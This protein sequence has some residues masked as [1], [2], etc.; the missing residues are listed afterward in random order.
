[1]VGHKALWIHIRVQL[2]CYEHPGLH[3][4]LIIWNRTHTN[5]SRLVVTGTEPYLFMS[6]NIWDTLEV[7]MCVFY[8][9][10][11][12]ANQYKLYRE[13]SKNQN[14]L[15]ESLR[16]HAGHLTWSPLRWPGTPPER[17]G[18]R[19]APGG[20]CHGRCSPSPPPK[21][22]GHCVTSFREQL[23]LIRSKHGRSSYLRIWAEG[24]F[25][26]ST[27]FGQVDEQEEEWKGFTAG[28]DGWYHVHI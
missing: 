4:T 9:Y 5:T 17:P 27:S 10:L 18:W 11:H 7:R 21:G 12:Y 20:T 14:I 3:P 13:Y 28:G 8:R 24:K 15:R 22:E 19:W 23:G 6:T 2:C 26:Q 1:M 25:G 16:G